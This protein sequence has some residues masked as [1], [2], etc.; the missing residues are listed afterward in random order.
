MWSGTAMPGN[1][2]RPSGKIGSSSATLANVPPTRRRAADQPVRPRIAPMIRRID[3]RALAAGGP[4]RAGSDHR[5]DARPFRSV[6]PRAETDVAATVEA[7]QPILDA[8]RARGVDAVLEF[9]RRFDRVEQTDV[10]VP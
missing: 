5:A 2:T 1:A 6:V 10:V 4:A 7:V 9:S 3:L 8:V